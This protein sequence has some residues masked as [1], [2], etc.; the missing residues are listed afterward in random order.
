MHFCP[1][2]GFKL[3]GDFAFCPNC[4]FKITKKNEEANIENSDKPDLI[5]ICDNCGEENNVFNNSAGFVC[6]YCG[7]KLKN[8]SAKNTKTSNLLSSEEPQKKIKIK[9]KK[10]NKNFSDSKILSS[11]IIFSI[12]GG[13]FLGSL[14]ILIFS[15]ILNKPALNQSNFTNQNQAANS[16]VDLNSLNKINELEAILKA[17]PDDDETL[18]QLAHLQN[19]SH[20]Y[21]KAIKN[22]SKYLIKHPENPDARID[23]GV[24]YYSLGDYKTAISE[25]E[26]ALK[27]SP[28]HQIGHLNLG[29]VNLTAGNIEKSKEW[30]RKAIEINPNS[31]VGKRAKELLEL[32]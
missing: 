6:S 14:L 12:T 24:C 4:G 20:F 18:L 15:G 25:M 1:E 28:K 9:N 11:K 7:M 26:K 13:A 17:N 27:Y 21:N 10:T 19:D 29:I 8:S 23:M 3:K 32:H 16:G 30:L 5:L 2:C 31:E 22:Y